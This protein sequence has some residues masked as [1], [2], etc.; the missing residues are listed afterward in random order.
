MPLSPLKP[1]NFRNDRK[2]V[3]FTLNASVPKSGVIQLYILTV[4]LKIIFNADQDILINPD[5]ILIKINTLRVF[6]AL[7]R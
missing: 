6:S 3:D 2:A 1:F 4:L 7:L 5:S